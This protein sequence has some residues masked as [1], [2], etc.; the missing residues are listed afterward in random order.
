[1]NKLFLRYQFVDKSN[2][3]KKRCG[4]IEMKILTYG[5]SSW[6][7]Y[8]DGMC[9][10]HTKEFLKEFKKQQQSRVDAMVIKSKK[11]I[12]RKINRDKKKKNNDN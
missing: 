2:L 3:R 7:Q 4:C 10:Q 12:A 1:M 6:I 9:Q 11:T 8:L 5:S